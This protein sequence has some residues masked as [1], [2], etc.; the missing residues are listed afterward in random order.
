[1]IPARPESGS[2]LRRFFPKGGFLSRAVVRLRQGTPRAAA[3]P[4]LAALLAAGLL[5]ACSIEL[6]TP[7]VQPTPTETLAPKL[8]LTSLLPTIAAV[9]TGTP[10]LTPTSTPDPDKPPEAGKR[11]FYD[12]L[13]G[14]LSGWGLS[15]N[16]V[17]TVDFSSGMLVFTVNAAYTTQVSE[18]PREIPADAYIEVTV[19]TL[20]CGE[21]LDTFGIIFRRSNDYSYRYAATCT[22]KLHFER[23]NGFDLEGASDWMDTLG[24]LQGAPAENRIGVLMQKNIFRFFVGGVEVFSRQDPMSLS[25]GLGLFIRTEKSKSLSVGFKDLSVYAIKEQ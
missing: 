4:A 23:F 25:G 21:G 17:G 12:P 19:Q 5:S 24:L 10:T 2:A 20:L 11:V 14:Q 8:P 6:I 7:T 16:E 1:V 15:R 13:D 3:V 9:P 18:L 22:G